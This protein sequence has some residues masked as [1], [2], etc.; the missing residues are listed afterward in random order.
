MDI[1]EFKNTYSKY[2][3]AVIWDWCAKPTAEEIDKQLYSFAQMGISHVYI[4]VSKGL[5]LPYLSDEY[6]ELVRTAARRCG[7]YGIALSLCDENSSSSGNGAGEVTSVSDYRVRD[8]VKAEKKDI[9]KFDEII[10]EKP[11]YTNVLRD[12]SKMRASSRAP[13]ADITNIFTTESFVEAVYAKYFRE[14]KRFLGFEIKSI[15]TGIDIPVS[16]TPCFIEALSR[17]G[18]SLVS[19]AEKLISGETHFA[20]NYYNCAS[21]LLAENFSK[22][23]HE[24][25]AEKSLSLCI[26]VSGKKEISR[27]KQYLCS[28]TVSVCVDTQKPDFIELKLAQTVAEQFEK[29]FSIRIN[30]PKL[31]PSSMRYNEGAFMASFGAD[32]IVYDSV[33]FSLSDRRKYEENTVSLSKYTE[34]SLSDRL[35]RLC[36][37]S[38]NTKSDARVL[39]IYDAQNKASFETCVSEML[40]RG[41]SF[42]L[43]EKSFFTSESQNCVKSIKIGCFEYDT[44]IISDK[45]VLGAFSGNSYS[46]FDDIDYTALQNKDSF[47]LTCDNTC[48]VNRRADNENEYIFVTARKDT[49]ITAENSGKPLFATDCAS[50]EIYKIPQTNG[51]FVFTLKAGKTALLIAS[52]SMDADIAPP[53]TDDMEFAPCQDEGD[54]LFALSDAEEN[55]LPLKNVNACFGKKS[56]R[57][58]S[59]DNLHREF[60]SL[61]DGET[62]KVKYPFYAEKNSIGE[63]RAYI[64][65]ADNLDFIELN[66]K[67]LEGLVPSPKDPRFMGIDITELIADGKNTFALEYK[68][69]NNYTPDYNSLTPSHFH[70]YN[71]TSFEP[72]YLC[73]D[74]DAKDATLTK[75]DS[76]ENDV[77]KSGM[78]YYY[79][80]LTYAVKL[81]ESNL[82]GKAMSV[83]GNFD[84]CRIKIGKRTLTFFSEI[85][86]TEIFNL[87][88]GT[89]AEITIYNTPY[90]LLRGANENPRPFGIESIKL[91]SFDY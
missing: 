65:N 71:V 35:A 78:G 20:E 66:G 21:D 82:A 89:V 41:I 32:S 1:R 42:H 76:Y 61:P 55:I 43:V 5:V 70:S 8:F 25:C 34:K 4:R 30:V 73:G 69:S 38:S 51:Q 16:S 36:F 63:V 29:G 74:F 9:E 45:S 22:I 88:C 10:E 15:S 19:G 85:P 90:N 62:V 57:E 87:D 49:C 60:Y 54:I 81:P 24:K 26:N 50:G 6:F 58:N 11:E 47:N 86:M 13:F 67:R 3:P 72:L 37:V 53:Y 77:T 33:A 17:C 68:K 14:C 84:I 31:A 28:D 52:C 75:L 56:F 59:I 40:K 46:V 48:F 27:Q 12:M 79:G 18:E 2:S 23:L 7:K 91:C 83:H 64:E 80:P 44:L 39:I